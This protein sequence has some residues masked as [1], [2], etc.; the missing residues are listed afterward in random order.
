MIFLVTGMP[1]GG[2]TY[3]AMRKID[4]SLAA[5]KVVVTNVKLSP[6]WAERIADGSPIARRN[7]RYRAR[8]IANYRRHMHFVENPGELMSIMVKGDEEGRAVAV[9]D[10]AGA[11]L[12]AREWN[13][14]CPGCEGKKRRDGSP[15]DHIPGCDGFTRKEI[16]T[17]FQRHRHY[18]FDVYLI[19]QLLSSIDKSVRELHE[20]N[21]ML[22]NLKNFKL[23][24]VKVFRRNRF[25][26]ITRWNS[27]D[28]HVLKR[29]TYT[30][31]KRVA[32]LYDTHA[33]KS[34]I[35]PEDAELILPLDPGQV[36]TRVPVKPRSVEMRK[37][38]KPTVTLSNVFLSIREV[39]ECSDDSQSS[40]S[41]RSRV[42]LR[43]LRR[44]G[45][46]S[47]E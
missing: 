24:G 20:E 36:V 44:A 39:P 34:D 10:E 16:V 19:A 21:I 22:K 27:T 3:F 4:Q 45:E 46:R 38:I 29:E 18:G 13:K 31:S 35:S 47:A 41:S 1:G 7:K 30:L 14:R 23:A 17:W 8:L 28:K 5:G 9:L 40:R 25:V 26:A 32:N 12:S 43:T 37:T 33:L 6:D 15:E 2:K 42:G 11:F